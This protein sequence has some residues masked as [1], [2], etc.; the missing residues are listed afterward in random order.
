MFWREVRT[1]LFKDRAVDWPIPLLP[2]IARILLM[3]K[4]FLQ[5]FLVG[6]SEV[7]AVS[8]NREIEVDLDEIDRLHT[9]VFVLRD[10]NAALAKDRDRLLA[11]R[12]EL[13][14]ALK[15]RSLLKV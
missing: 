10:A 7:S 3:S 8:T 6:G 15:L 5:Q 4:N 1:A 12:D 9:E 11:E 14:A 13:R 2:G